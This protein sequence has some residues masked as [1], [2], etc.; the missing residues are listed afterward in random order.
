[1]ENAITAAVG[2]V[3]APSTAPDPDLVTALAEETPGA[4]ASADHDHGPSP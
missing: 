2:A 1:M 3:E 4:V